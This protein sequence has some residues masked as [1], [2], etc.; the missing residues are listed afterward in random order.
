VQLYHCFAVILIIGIG[1]LAIFGNGYAQ[2]GIN[3][4]QPGSGLSLGAETFT[5]FGTG[6]SV[7]FWLHSNR[8]D[9]IDRRSFNSGVRVHTA[10]YHDLPYGWQLD[11]GLDVLARHSERE[12]FR[13]HQAWVGL[14]YRNFRLYA[15]RQTED[16]FG[17]VHTPTSLG[18]MDWSPNIRPLNK[19]AIYTTDFQAVP[20]TRGV[21]FFDAY[22]AHG[23]L[24]D[25][26]FV[27]DAFLHQKYLYLRFFDDDLLINPRA[28]IVHNVMWGGVSQNPRFGR[29]PSTFRDYLRVII[30]DTGESIDDFN[31]P[32][33]YGNSV[34]LYDF[35]LNVNLDRHRITA[36]RQFYIENSPN[37]NFKAPW[38][39]MW[40]L[41]YERRDQPDALI[42]AVSYEHINTLDQL[43]S[44]PRRDGST[45]NYYNHTIWRSG[46][47]YEGRVIGN[48]LY[49]SD[50][51]HYDVVNNELFAHHL[52]IAGHLPLYGSGS[53]SGTGSSG[54]SASAGSRTS[55]GSGTEA[56]RTASS[57]RTGS[58]RIH[59]L[60][61]GVHY[62]FFTTFSRNYGAQ[63]HDLGIDGSRQ[64]SFML[65]LDASPLIRSRSDWG[66]TIAFAYDRGELYTDNFGV[67]FSIRW[68][69]NFF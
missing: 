48:P 6:G 58:S 68:S 32:G 21:L 38:D 64:W 5:A 13:L 19:I 59:L 33:R 22:Y 39:G 2:S 16:F 25:D 9:I 51:D 54:R 45:V 47:T 55:T 20:F 44:H 60:P 4:T 65:E 49:F 11:A 40:G 31:Q 56:A 1:C 18:T 61:E 14:T 35:A 46:W 36:Y 37:A 66:S 3:H 41:I 8:Y 12:E 7:P 23:W 50:D 43:S 24:D 69:T 62:R 27:R 42:Q 53:G 63:R 30:N 28:G 26:R 29:L 17:T 34:G 57:G 67:L 10:G 15:G 52:G